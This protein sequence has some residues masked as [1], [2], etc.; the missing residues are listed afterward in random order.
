MKALWN[1]LIARLVYWITPKPPVIDPAPIIKVQAP[2]PPLKPGICECEHDR[3]YHVGGKGKCTV[4]YPKDEEWPNGAICSCVV[5]I[6]DDDNDDDNEPET[7]TPS[8]LEKLY[9]R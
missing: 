1:A 6:L 4:E 7:P 9:Q 3:C 8:E 5:F 2:E